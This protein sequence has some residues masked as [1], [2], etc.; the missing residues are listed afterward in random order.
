MGKKKN[1]GPTLRE[2]KENVEI[3][4]RQGYRF[5]AIRKELGKADILAYLLLTDTKF[6]HMFGDAYKMNLTGL[7]SISHFTQL[8][9]A[10]EVADN[11]ITFTSSSLGQRVRISSIY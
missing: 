7:D 6:R 5:P 9:Y 11:K 8:D 2:C 4:L 1:Q 3:M 10:I